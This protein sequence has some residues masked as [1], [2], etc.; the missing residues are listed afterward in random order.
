MPAGVV[1]ILTGHHDDIADP[2]GRHADIDA[3]WS[4]GDPTRAAV[5]ETGAAGNLKRTWISALDW[6]IDNTKTILPHATEIKNIWVPY[7]A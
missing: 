5:V 6:S 3:V 1:N 4:L 2:M 7:G